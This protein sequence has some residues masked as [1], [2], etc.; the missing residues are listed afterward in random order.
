[1]AQTALFIT[2][3][4]LKRNSIIDGNVDVNVFIQYVKIAQELHI[5]NFTGTKLY[6]TLSNA[7]I[8]NNLNRNTPACIIYLILHVYFSFQEFNLS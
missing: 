1:M 3:K 4:D 5:R 8:N 6:N 7:I 2:T